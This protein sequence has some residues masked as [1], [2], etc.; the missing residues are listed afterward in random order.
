MVV[1]YLIKHT[2]VT[3]WYW[4]GVKKISCNIFFI[5]KLA[6]HSSMTD[7]FPLLILACGISNSCEWQAF[8]SSFV[9]LHSL[10]CRFYLQTTSF[11]SSSVIP[12]RRF[13]IISPCH[14]LFGQLL[15]LIIIYCDHNA[16][17]SSLAHRKWCEEAVFIAPIYRDSLHAHSPT[18]TTTNNTKS[19]QKK[20]KSAVWLG[21]L[22]CNKYWS[23]WI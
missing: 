10:T 2:W 16:Y 12:S 17:L 7:T 5:L 3:C 20:K 15:G 4:E 9:N 18:T 22:T 8:F 11:L 1:V 23:K 14:C 19:K 13:E 21:V 6:A